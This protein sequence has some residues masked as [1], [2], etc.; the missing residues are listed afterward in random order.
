MKS[1]RKSVFFLHLLKKYKLCYFGPLYSWMKS[2]PLQSR[3]QLYIILFSRCHR[4]RISHIP[5][6]VTLAWL[7]LRR[8]QS[9]LSFMSYSMFRKQRGQSPL[10]ALV[11]PIAW[12]SP[13]LLLLCS[14]MQCRGCSTLK[15]KADSLVKPMTYQQ[16]TAKA[17]EFVPRAEH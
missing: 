17:P 15:L 3:T 11:K 13:Y 12:G 4:I 14:E 16:G 6:P 2:D 10:R 9:Q 8:T 5:Q 1:Q 7:S